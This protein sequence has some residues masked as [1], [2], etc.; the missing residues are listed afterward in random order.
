MNTENYYLFFS[1]EHPKFDCNKP[2]FVQKGKKQI[3]SSK[4]NEKIK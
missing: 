3:Q 2:Y 1:V 4:L